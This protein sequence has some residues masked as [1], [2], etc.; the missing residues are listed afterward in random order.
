[1]IRLVNSTS[2]NSKMIFFMFLFYP[3]STTVPESRSY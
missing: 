3:L 1:M 2:V